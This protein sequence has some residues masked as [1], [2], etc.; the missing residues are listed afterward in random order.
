MKPLICYALT[1]SVLPRFYKAQEIQKK[2]P[3]F[4]QYDKLVITDFT[5]KVDTA[6]PILREDI[7]TADGIFSLGHAYNVAFWYA[8]ENG[9][10]CVLTGD[11]DRIILN[12]SEKLPTQGLSC[13]DVYHATAKD[14]VDDMLKNIDTLKYTP[15]SFFVIP[16]SVFMKCH[17]CEEFVGYAWD[18]ID[19]V[20]NVCPSHGIT[21]PK[22]F[23]KLRGLHLYHK[24]R[25]FTE[26]SKE[27]N[28]R[29]KIRNEKIP[30]TN[31]CP[32]AWEK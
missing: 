13:V 3:A 25:L 1:E 15:S 19:Y 2:F 4:D 26:T 31:R 32:W 30:G 8:A 11:S 23:P 22:E 29:F 6:W 5:S 18:D 12:V 17:F 16:R 24:E 14:T 10:E 21:Q 27:N 28:R 9:Y 20:Y 7:F